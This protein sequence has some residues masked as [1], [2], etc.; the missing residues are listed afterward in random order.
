MVGVDSYIQRVVLATEET[1]LTQQVSHN[2]NPARGH[3]RHEGQR[4]TS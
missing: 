3:K 4:V 1:T 2:A